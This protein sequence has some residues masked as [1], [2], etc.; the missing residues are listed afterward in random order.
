MC[1]FFVLDIVTSEV[2]ALDFW[3]KDESIFLDIAFSSIPLPVFS[4]R[5]GNIIKSVFGLFFNVQI[6][7]AIS[8]Y[9]TVI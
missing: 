6:N 1:K 9:I 3:A 2:F 7:T 4:T 8:K 5:I